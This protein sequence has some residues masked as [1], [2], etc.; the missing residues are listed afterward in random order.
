MISLRQHSPATEALE[1]LICKRK[2]ER[3]AKSHEMKQRGESQST[4]EDE[5]MSFPKIEW[6]L[7]DDDES[8][9]QQAYR[10]PQDDDDGESECSSIHLPYERT[11]RQF[12]IDNSNCQSRPCM[13]RTKSLQSSLCYLVEQV[14]IR[15]QK[16]EDAPAGSWGQFV[17][18][19]SDDE[20]VYKQGKQS[21][22]HQQTANLALLPIRAFTIR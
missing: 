12:I 2:L 16:A 3:A 19:S 22:T 6:V 18:D 4:K 11:S 7:E 15:Q 10:P 14:A 5:D 20:E 21:R 8:D 1:R 13:Y 17:W 9:C